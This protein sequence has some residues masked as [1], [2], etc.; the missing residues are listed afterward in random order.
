MMREFLTSAM[1]DKRY[2]RLILWGNLLGSVIT[3]MVFIALS[4]IMTDAGF[5]NVSLAGTWTLVFVIS[6]ALAVV[7]LP[8]TIPAAL[9]GWLVAVGLVGK[10][11]KNHHRA[12]LAALVSSLTSALGAAFLMPI[13]FD[14]GT[15]FDLPGVDSSVF[16]AIILPG[17]IVGNLL[18]A[19]WLYRPELKPVTRRETVK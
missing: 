3:A 19:F 8:A 14:Q 13:I 10:R 17:V 12:R 2:L 5:G 7:A 9:M 11:L 18:A 16:L 4:F 15:V 1:L 6:V